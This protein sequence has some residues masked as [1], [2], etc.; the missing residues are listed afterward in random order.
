MSWLNRDPE[1]TGDDW[2]LL[3]F[4]PSDSQGFTISKTHEKPQSKGLPPAGAHEPW[5]AVTSAKSWS[6][7]NE[8]NWSEWLDNTPLTMRMKAPLEPKSELFTGVN[9]IMSGR[10]STLSKLPFTR[11]TFTSIKSHFKIHSSI[12]RAINRNTSCNVSM[13][14][15]NWKEEEADTRSIV[16]NCRTADAWDGDMALSLTFFPDSL[17]TNVVWY[18]CDLSK[19]DVDGYLLTDAEIITSRLSKF[20]GQIY[21]P[22][23]LPTIFADFER[24]RQVTLAR[25]SLNKMIQTVFEN[26]YMDPQQANMTT[27]STETSETKKKKVDDRPHSFTFNNIKRKAQQLWK[28]GRRSND[29]GSLNL[30]ADVESQN[31]MIRSASLTLNKEPHIVPWLKNSY[32]KNGLENWRAQLL[33]M[34]DHVDELDK[35]CFGIKITSGREDEIEALRETGAIIKG[36]LRELVSEYDEFIREITNVMEAMNLAVQLEL[37]NASR[38][39]TRINQQI[40]A[41]SLEVAEMTRNDGSLM[42]SIAILGMIFLPATFVSTFFSM[43]FFQW[44]NGSSKGSV[45]RDLW[46]YVVATLAVTFLTLGIFYTFHLRR[47]RNTRRRSAMFSV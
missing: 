22:M 3:S 18:G 40:S 25:E 17:I 14:F 37:N 38:K 10:T 24:T 16:Y 47:R 32:L 43:G 13:F 41:T 12:V 1:L 5:H 31:S 21:H 45:S 11:E 30:V 4:S 15:Y 7:P 26:A 34:I 20:D 39:D 9:L 42:K 28:S 29:S 46:V 23:L 44:K 35:T 8:I 19:H 2:N 33:R 6:L 27:R 36:R